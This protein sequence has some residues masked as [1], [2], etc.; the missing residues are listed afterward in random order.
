MILMAT[1]IYLSPSILMSSSYNLTCGQP[2][3]RTRFEIE[4]GAAAVRTQPLFIGCSLY[5][6]SY[7]MPWKQALVAE[8]YLRVNICP[9]RSRSSSFLGRQLHQPPACALMSLPLWN[10]SPSVALSVKASSNMV[11]FSSGNWE[12]WN[13]NYYHHQ[14]KLKAIGLDSDPFNLPKHQQSTDIDS[15]LGIGLPD[16]YCYLI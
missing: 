1:H 8:E 7:S 10:M 12:K 2:D 6:L 13:S 14:F 15:Q 11:A 3:F 9:Q 16:L 4:P 5:Q